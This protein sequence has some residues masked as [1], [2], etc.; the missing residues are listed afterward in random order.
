[1]HDK[2]PGRAQPSKSPA[3]KVEPRRRIMGS[4][5]KY[6]LKKEIKSLNEKLKK[7]DS[8]MEKMTRNESN[9]KFS[10]KLTIN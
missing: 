5:D 1:V 8:M 10:P 4:P 9:S 7:N 2:S 6:E 3:K